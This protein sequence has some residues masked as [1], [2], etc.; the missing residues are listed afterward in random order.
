MFDNTGIPIEEEHLQQ[1][2]TQPDQ[3]STHR[4]FDV[5]KPLW[6]NIHGPN[7]CGH[8]EQFINEKETGYR[9]IYKRVCHN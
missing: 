8:L 9:E 6:G 4:Y 3:L 1:S 2:I 7:Q 5:V